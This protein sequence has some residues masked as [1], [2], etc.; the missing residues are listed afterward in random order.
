MENAKTKNTNE[1]VI[2]GKIK[3]IIDKPNSKICRIVTSGFS[4]PNYPTIHFIKE[5]K[6]LL[7]GYNAGDYVTIKGRV[8]SFKNTA[9]NEKNQNVVYLTQVFEA[10]HIEK[11]ATVSENEFGLETAEKRY[12]FNNKIV[13]CGTIKKLRDNNKEFISLVLSVD[14]ERGHSDTVKVAVRTTNKEIFNRKYKVGD[15]VCVLAIAST[16]SYMNEDRRVY[17][18]EVLCDMLIKND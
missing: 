17:K 12:S 9:E 4:K 10:K 6:T 14:N 5:N 13:L 15:K 7:D 1:L 2:T 18:E 8:S 16:R 11:A 3:S